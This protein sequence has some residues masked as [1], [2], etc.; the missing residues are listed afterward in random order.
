MLKSAQSRSFLH[1]HT[2]T[3]THGCLC[4]IILSSLFILTIITPSYSTNVTGSGNECNEP[5]LNTDTGPA[6]LRAQWNANII[7]LEW[8]SDGTKITPSNSTANTCTYDGTITLPSTNPTKEGYTFGGWEVVAAAPAQCNLSNL[9]ASIGAGFDGDHRRWKNISNTYSGWSMYERNGVENSSD[10]NP[11]EF[12]ATFD[13]GTIKGKATC[14]AKN[15]NSNNYEWNNDSSN[16]TATTSELSSV[17]G[18]KK[19]CWCQ[20]INYNNVCVFSEPK[21]VFMA[22]VGE[23]CLSSCAYTCSGGFAGPTSAAIAFRTA[24]YSVTE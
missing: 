23:Q 15:G 16:W 9:D 7:N 14:S 1:T 13:Y 20:I 17:S 6:T 11:G 3:H 2:H 24:I 18:Q 5:T 21:L 22:D 10:L 4:K 19:Y 12:A 8:Y